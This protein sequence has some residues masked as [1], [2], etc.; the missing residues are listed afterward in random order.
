MAARICEGQQQRWELHREEELLIAAE[1]DA[2][3]PLG[4][5]C[6]AHVWGKTPHCGQRTTGKQ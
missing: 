1:D 4:K 3:E 6:F 2:P 5:H